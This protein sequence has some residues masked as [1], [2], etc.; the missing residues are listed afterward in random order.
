MRPMCSLSCIHTHLY[1]HAH[2]SHSHARAHH[3]TH[4]ATKMHGRLP[5][6]L[7]PR[8]NSSPLSATLAANFSYCKILSGQGASSMA[9]CMACEV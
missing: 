6:H 8:N 2:H 9:S 3:H 7:G 1:T 5:A 4:A